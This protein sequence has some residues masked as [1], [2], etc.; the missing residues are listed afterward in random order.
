[1]DY[2]L[3]ALQAL[4]DSDQRELTRF[5]ALKKNKSDRK[6]LSLLED[7][8]KG[9]KEKDLS[10]QETDAQ[11]QNRKRIWHSLADFI[12]WKE[13][14]DDTSPIAKM[15]SY[16][17]L[18]RYLF[19]LRLHKPGWK[20]LNKA[21]DLAQISERYDIL[22]SIF[23][24]KLENSQYDFAED[25]QETI[26]KIEIN[27]KLL[28]IDERILI[29]TNVIRNKLNEMKE[30]PRKISFNKII[31]ETLDNFDLSFT[32]FKSARQIHDLL[33]I[34]RSTYLVV[35]NLHNFESFAA[36][37]YDRIVKN[38]GFDVFNHYYKLEILYMIAH[39]NFRNRNFERANLYL[40]ELNR[41]IELFNHDHSSR[42]FPKYIAMKTNLLSFEGKNEE[43]IKLC[44]STLN[45]KKLKISLKDSYSV[46]LNLIVFN[47][48]AKRFRQANK[49][50]LF[51]PHTDDFLVKRL[52]VEWVMRKNLIF[53]IVQYEVGHEEICLSTIRKMERKYAGV[54]RM[55]GYERAKNY[56]ILLKQFVNDPHQFSKSKFYEDAQKQLFAKSFDMEEYKMIAFYSWLKSKAE[57][58]DYYETMRELIKMNSN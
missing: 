24:L 3:T 13:M 44:E 56:L 27:N 26:R 14:Q 37:Q 52:G 38:N 51:S 50:F 18:A 36:S 30:L 28:D 55:H 45:D 47:F 22:K 2:L 9:K 25:I 4:D 53:A 41:N 49:L 10:K 54:L 7:L 1:M 29:A 42:Y 46:N 40:E 21:E 48:N 5:I 23:M 32:S 31:E 34:I 11:N 12:A 35:N 57:K 20:F 33:V 19:T 16:V 43:A 8:L 39:A 6:D 58:L 17:S 15:M